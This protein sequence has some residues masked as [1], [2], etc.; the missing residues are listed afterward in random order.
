MRNKLPFLITLLTLLALAIL[1]TIYLSWFFYPMEISWLGL[2]ELSGRSPAIIEKN[3]HILMDY[4]TNPFNWRLEMPNFPS[5][6]DG[7]YHFES[8]KKL[9]H[10]VQLISLIGLALTVWLI[11]K[12]LKKDLPFFWSRGLAAAAALPILIAVLTVLVGFDQFFILFHQLLFPDDSTWL[13]HPD[14]DPVILILPEIFF[15]HC[16][17]LFLFCYES[18]IGL[19]FGLLKLKSLN[20]FKNSYNQ[21]PIKSKNMIE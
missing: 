6:S 13:F 3:F 7:L 12:K 14:S 2:E 20:F 18:L 17:V 19:A 1:L 9:F 15:L 5:S 11:R 16:F 4:L 21:S 8:V 10:L